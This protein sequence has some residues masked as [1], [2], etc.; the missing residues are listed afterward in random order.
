MEL[1]EEYNETLLSFSDREPVAGA[2]SNVLPPVN[3][4]FPFP[5]ITRGS[6]LGAEEA[7]GCVVLQ[8]ELCDEYLGS[9]LS[10]VEFESVAGAVDRVVPPAEKE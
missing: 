4:E 2:V 3:K 7:G 5:S 6:N 8:A 9:L 10:F 1:C